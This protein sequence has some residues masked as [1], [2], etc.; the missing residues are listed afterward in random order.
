MPS[1][2][3]SAASRSLRRRPHVLSRGSRDV[4]LVARVARDVVGLRQRAPP[5]RARDDVELPRSPARPRT[6]STARR[7][8]TRRTARSTGD[9]AFPGEPSRR[10]AGARA[11]A[12]ARHVRD[13][14]TSAAAHVRPR[15]TRASA[16]TARGTGRRRAR[17]SSTTFRS[18][19]ASCRTQAGRAPC[20]TGLGLDA[21]SVASERHQ[22]A[23]GVE[24]R[25]QVSALDQVV[26]TLDQRLTSNPV[27]SSALAYVADAWSPSPALDGAGAL[28]A[29]ATHVARSDGRR[30]GVSA[31]DPHL[32]VVRAVRASPCGSHT[33]TRP[34]RRSRCKR[35]GMDSAQPDAPFVP[36]APERGDAYELSYER[37]RRARPSTADAVQQGEHDRIDVFPVDLR[38]AVAA[39]ASPGAALGIPQNV[40]SAARERRRAR[41]LAR[42]ACRSPRRTCARARR[43]RRSSGSTISTRRPSPRTTSFRWDTF[44]T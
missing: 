39:N 32:S 28:R 34:S 13:R 37:G 40:G 38:N 5:R 42:T 23:Y 19:T 1:T 9:D 17:R 6:I 44:P 26:P 18:R 31:L 29:N 2:C 27:L 30:Y 21:K 16:H 22:V 8:R 41:L 12:R 7:S 10:R 20:S 3:R 11:D 24:L 15:S 36:L 4:R 14:E 43:A 35:S 25:R 33:I